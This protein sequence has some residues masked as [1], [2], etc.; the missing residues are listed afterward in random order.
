MDTEEVSIACKICDPRHWSHRFMFLIFICF[1]CFG[2][3]YVYDNPAALQAQ[4]QD[5]CMY[6]CMYL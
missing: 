2:N 6:V 1:L 4:F 3:Y 5:V